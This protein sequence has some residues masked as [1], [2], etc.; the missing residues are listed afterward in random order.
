MAEPFCIAGIVNKPCP[1]QVIDG[2]VDIDRPDFFCAQ[3]RPDF[4]LALLPPSKYIQ[5][6]VLG[7]FFARLVEYFQ[8]MVLG[9]LRTFREPVKFENL[10]VDIERPAVA[11]NQ[12]D[13]ANA[14][15][16]PFNRL[17]FNDCV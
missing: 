10:L 4:A 13:G 2:L 15:F 17:Y 9:D 8:E 7:E 14:P 12:A 1:L 6:I 5:R 3:P 11:K 16:R